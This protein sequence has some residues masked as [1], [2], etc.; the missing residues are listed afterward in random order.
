M[1]GYDFARWTALGAIAIA[2]VALG[3]MVWTRDV[4][5]F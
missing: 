5:R 1:T 4:R 2:V 3:L